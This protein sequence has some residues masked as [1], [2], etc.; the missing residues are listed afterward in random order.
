ML[1]IKRSEL[2]KNWFIDKDGKSCI[3]GHWAKQMGCNMETKDSFQQDLFKR[4]E[5]LWEETFHKPYPIDIVYVNNN[6]SGKER[7]NRLKKLFP[8]PIE[9]VD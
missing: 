2:I 7:E 8:E 1:T 5:K 3:M 6:F 4:I 9:F